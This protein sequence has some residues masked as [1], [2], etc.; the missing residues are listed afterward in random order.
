MSE[1]EAK[2]RS[3]VG[4]TLSSIYQLLDAATKPNIVYVYNLI[5]N[6]FHF[7]LSLRLFIL[8][9]WRGEFLKQTLPRCLRPSEEEPIKTEVE[10]LPLQFLLR[11][12]RW[13]EVHCRPR[14][15]Q[16]EMYET[17]ALTDYV[18]RS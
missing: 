9:W 16:H 14:P 8:T 11:R 7:T 17:F 18:C 12:D 2:R 5:S 3:L 15:A 10:I 4:H 13:T 1:E 6:K